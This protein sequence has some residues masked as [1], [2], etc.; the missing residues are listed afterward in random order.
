MDT[1]KIIRHTFTYI[2]INHTSP[3]YEPW[4]QH[5]PSTLKMVG[6]HS[7]HLLKIPIKKQYRTSLKYLKPEDYDLYLFFIPQDTHPRSSTAKETI[8]HSKNHF[9]FTLLMMQLF[10]HLQHQNKMSKLSLTWILTTD[11]TFFL[12]LYFQWV[13]NLEDLEPELKNLWSLFDLAKGKPSHNYTLKLFK[14]ESIFNAKQ[15][16][17]TPPPPSKINTSWSFQNWDN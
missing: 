17:M 7:I 5:S 4:G 14:E 8:K 10:I 16:N 13:L 6:Y 11:L 1:P 2:T 9:D 15:L 12:L 3:L